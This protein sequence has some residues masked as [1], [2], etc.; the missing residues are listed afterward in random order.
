MP[1]RTSN[2]DIERMQTYMGRSFVSLALEAL[3]LLYLRTCLY[4]DTAAPLIGSIWKAC[5]NRICV[6]SFSVDDPGRVIAECG[7]SSP[8]KH[9]TGHRC[10]VLSIGGMQLV[11][12]YAEILVL[13][14][15]C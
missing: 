3:S 6:S 7:D 9:H 5:S 10:D 11:L 12:N 15:A 14:G 8:T 4:L 13:C 2:A 1:A